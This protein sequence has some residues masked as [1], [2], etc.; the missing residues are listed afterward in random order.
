[1]LGHSNPSFH[2]QQICK[3]SSKLDDLKI[4]KE[5]FHVA[6][7]KKYY[8]WPW[9][10]NWNFF[11]K[12]FYIVFTFEFFYLALLLAWDVI[13]IILTR[14]LDECH[15]FSIWFEQFGPPHMQSYVEMGLLLVII[16]SGHPQQLPSRPHLWV[17][18]RD[19]P[20]LD[21]CLLSSNGFNFYIKKKKIAVLIQQKRIAFPISTKKKH[22]GT[23]TNAIKGEE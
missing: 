13:N 6:W 18:I 9:S 7:V 11:S 4:W 3:R 22:L 2:K 14:L 15:N 1:M 16:T 12:I 19:F 23:W 8:F 10:Y 21:N 17:N 20:R 5:H